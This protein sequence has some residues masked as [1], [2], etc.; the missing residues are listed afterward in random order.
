LGKMVHIWGSATSPMIYGDTCF[1][2]FGPGETT[3]LLAVNKKTGATLW[4]KDEETGYGKPPTADV[5]KSASSK[6]AGP[7]ATDIGSWSTPT[8]MKVEGKDQLLLSWP[9]RLAA[10]EP[11]TGKEVWTCSGL[12]PLVY[13]SPIFADG[14]VVAMGGYGGRAIAVRAGGSGDVTATRRIWE[15][16]KEPQ[17]IGSGV[18]H[19]GH[20]YIHNDPGTANCIDL[21]TGKV[22]WQERLKGEA[23]TG[24]NW[25][26]VMLSG[27]NCYTITQGGDC[28]V[29]KASPTFQLVAANAL[30][31]R[32]NSS[33]VPSDGELFIRPHQALWCISD[34]KK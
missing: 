22:I 24:Q 21:K 13:S 6:N 11:Q 32:S 9:R 19:E 2:N 17:R 30:G 12:N 27:D 25:S 33:V 29:F 23:A 7:M 3:Y 1:L 15:D 34:K 8:I 28:F 20:I 31:E 26:S 5:R 18:I 10:Y 14:I 16:P 4:K